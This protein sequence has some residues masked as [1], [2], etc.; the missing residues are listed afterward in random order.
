MSTPPLPKGLERTRGNRV[1][2]RLHSAAIHLLRRARQEDRATG[3]SPERLSLL[4]V[5][6]FAGARTPSELAAIEMVSRPAITRTLNA[7]EDDG[8]VVRRRSDSDRRVLRVHA[9]AKGEKLM[10][11][12]RER[13]VRRIAGE[14]ESLSREELAVLDTATRALELLGGRR[15]G[16]ARGPE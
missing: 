5:L 15:G 16:T 11:T 14:L 3:L 12:G 9:T 7:L 10:E 4:S 13:R 6:V 1:A 8:L 2:N